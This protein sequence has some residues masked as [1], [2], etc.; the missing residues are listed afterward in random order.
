MLFFCNERLVRR[1]PW[2]AH[3]KEW[4]KFKYFWCKTQSL[5]ST[6]PYLS[7]STPYIM[8]SCQLKISKSKLLHSRHILC[9]HMAR[10]CWQAC[11]I[12][13]CGE[14]IPV[15]ESKHAHIIWDWWYH[16]GQYWKRSN[17]RMLYCGV[18][19]WALVGVLHKEIEYLQNQ[20]TEG[21][22]P[23]LPNRTCLKFEFQM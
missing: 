22:I 9:G 13:L 11:N 17:L 23:N 15:V 20:T 1:A 21:L 14:K 12:S 4:G 6:H 3:A 5:K 7:S 18:A 19:P 2:F 16:K 10:S 8:W